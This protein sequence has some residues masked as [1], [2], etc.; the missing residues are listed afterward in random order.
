MVGLA[1]C[2][3]DPLD[4]A[5][6]AAEDVP[7]LTSLSVRRDGEVLHE[8]YFRGTDASSPHDVRSV[9][10]TVTALLIGDAIDR[11]CVT[12]VDQPIGELLGDA[13]PADSAKA[14]IRVRDLLTMTSGL[15][16]VE[17]GSLGYNQWITS[18]D[19]VD[20]VLARD[21]VATP[22]TVFNYNSGAL[23]LLSAIL[24]H[25]C[26]P[27]EDFAADHLFGPLGFTAAGW[28]VDAQQ[29]TNGAAG[30]ALTNPQ[31]AAIGQLVLDRGAF[32][33]AQLVSADYVDQMTT[34]QIDTGNPLDGTPSYGFGIWL[35][36][37]EDTGRFALAEGFGGQFIAVVPAA[38]AVVVATTRWMDLARDGQADSDFNALYNRL[39]TRVLP[40][41]IDR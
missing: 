27:T 7:N 13:A 11:G 29:L 4:D 34:P 38:R 33:G 17:E 41:L 21:L 16:W 1:T 20:Y 28:E 8:A 5:I 40:A 10:K 19:Q 30:L 24:T 35:G 39:V 6:S 37:R 15:D 32:A 14:A 2:A 12:S 36:D 26:A 25:A 9:T 3:S 23:H 31:L 22:G 18:D